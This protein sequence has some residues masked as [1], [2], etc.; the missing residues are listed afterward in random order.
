[1]DRSRRSSKRIGGTLRLPKGAEV[2]RRWQRETKD[3]LASYNGDFERLE[4]LQK[5]FLVFTNQEPVKWAKQNSSVSFMM[6]ILY[7]MNDPCYLTH[8]QIAR[9]MQVDPK[10]IYTY[11]SRH[12]LRRPRGKRFNSR[13]F[14]PPKEELLGFVPEHLP[15]DLPSYPWHTGQG[16][17]S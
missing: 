3:N 8:N 14:H 4:T 6:E 7:H 10:T 13:H 5:L 12:G 15:L 17:Q 16:L 11:L 9:V 1:M 2:R